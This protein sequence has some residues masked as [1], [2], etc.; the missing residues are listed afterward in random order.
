MEPSYSSTKKRSGNI[1]ADSQPVL[2]KS[3]HFAGYS[4]YLAPFKPG[5]HYFLTGSTI[6]KLSGLQFE[7]LIN[8]NQTTSPYLLALAERKNNELS[9]YDGCKLH[10]KID[11]GEEIEN[12][13]EIVS[14]F[15][16][17]IE[18]LN[19][20]EIIVIDRT[21]PNATSKLVERLSK[22]SDGDLSAQKELAWLYANGLHLFEQ[23][24]YGIG[25]NKVEAIRLCHLMESNSEAVKAYLNITSHK[26]NNHIDL[27][28]KE[29]MNLFFP[30]LNLSATN[31]NAEAQYLLGKLYYEH[32]SG[33][34]PYLPEFMSFNGN[35]EYT[36]NLYAQRAFHWLSLSTDQ[37]YKE[38]P[39]ALKIMGEI[40]F[41][42][43][44]DDAELAKLAERGS[45]SAQFYYANNF[46]TT[47]VREYVRYMTLAA[48]QSHHNAQCSLGRFYLTHKDLVNHAKG[49]PLLLS[50]WKNSYVEDR[51]Y[52]REI[53][54]NLRDCLETNLEEDAAVT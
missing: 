45:S 50:A 37:R 30:R 26:I 6:D 20:N 16:A 22:S 36:Q 4:I 23:G 2:K 46:V 24:S 21:L 8:D 27:G 42:Y 5:H 52:A 12:S 29:V 1:F 48:D 34:Y 9:P 41:I 19:N 32:L 49:F 14:I 10:R 28:T 51:N 44:Y 3:K 13:Q 38:T 53:K 18:R 17:T 15:Y 43:N 39:N 11:L 25:V 31:G 40:V 7:Q 47:N 33:K 54:E 35:Q